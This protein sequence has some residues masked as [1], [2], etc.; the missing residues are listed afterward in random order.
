MQKYIEKMILPNV[1]VS[2]SFASSYNR[3]AFARML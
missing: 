3:F 2:P 1:A